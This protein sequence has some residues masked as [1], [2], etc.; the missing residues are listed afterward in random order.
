VAT[1]KLPAG[2][3]P[4]WHEVRIRTGGSGFSN[5]ARIA[6]DIPPA[7]DR[8]TIESACDGRTWS[9]NEIT[10]GFLS[11]WVGGFPD[12]ADQGNIRVLVDGRS[13]V[14]LFAGEP[15]ENG[16]RQVNASLRVMV[17]SGAHEIAVEVGG[18]RSNAVNMTVTR[19]Q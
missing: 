3:A 18:T 15:D 2:L 19:E 12:N 6:V 16:A 11:L 17:H 7:C 13:Q 14:T 10:S 1:F 8:L 5:T 4:G 9:R